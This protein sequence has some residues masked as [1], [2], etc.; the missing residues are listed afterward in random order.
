MSPPAACGSSTVVIPPFRSTYAP[1]PPPTTPVT[2]ARTRAPARASPLRDFLGG[3]GGSPAP[4][5]VQGSYCPQGAPALRRLYR[6]STAGLMIT[7]LDHS[8][9]DGPVV[10]KG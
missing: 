1:M 2:S 5:A 3:S 4:P 10:P 6:H 7:P 8:I 9:H